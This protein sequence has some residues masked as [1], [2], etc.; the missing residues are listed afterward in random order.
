[1]SELELYLLGRC[2]VS[3]ER[4]VERPVGRLWFIITHAVTT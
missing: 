2:T 3:S 4:I 1:V